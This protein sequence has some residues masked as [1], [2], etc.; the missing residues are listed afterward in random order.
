MT[1]QT[2]PCSIPHDHR[3]DPGSVV[4]GV[5][6][7]ADTHYGAVLDGVG[8]LLDTRQFPADAHGPPAAGM[9]ALLR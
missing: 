6:T 4:G 2:L 7:H 1:A 9:D 3:P 8:R 5:D